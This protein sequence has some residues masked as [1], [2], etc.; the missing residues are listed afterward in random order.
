M[1]RHRLLDGVHIF[2]L[3]D[4]LHR[5]QRDVARRAVLKLHLA[6]ERAGVIIEPFAGK[7][8]R[9]AF[10]QRG[11]HAAVLIDERDSVT[12]FRVGRRVLRKLLLR[13]RRCCRFNVFALVD[14][15]HRAQRDVARQSLFQLHL[16]P[17][18][19][20]FIVIHVSR[21][22]HHRTFADGIHHISVPIS[23]RYGI[24]RAGKARRVFRQ[25]FLYNLRPRRFGR[26]RRSVRRNGHLYAVRHA[27]SAHIQQR[28]ACHLIVHADPTAA[29]RRTIQLIPLAVLSLELYLNLLGVNAAPRQQLQPH[30]RLF[31]VQIDPQIVDA[32]RDL[33][34]LVG[35][36]PSGENL[37]AGGF[38]RA[39]R[40]KRH[41][42]QH[43]EQYAKYP[44]RHIQS[45]LMTNT[46]KSRLHCNIT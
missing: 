7:A 29:I 12:R 27:V 36:A 9:R 18:R 31:R 32:F 13:Y 11:Q 15:L 23:K 22:A 30:G 1:R 33:D 43:S 37:H 10:V 34:R 39:K 2:A 20:D 6:P 26:L 35:L 40:G 19:A 8:H 5:A 14:E 46:T 17:E 38:Y 4:E 24:A 25:L 28:I 45:L 16:A 44:S 21:E 3:V 41:S 42:K